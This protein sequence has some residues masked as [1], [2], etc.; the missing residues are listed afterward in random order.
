MHIPWICC[1]CSNNDKDE[2]DGGAPPKI[3]ISASFCRTRTQEGGWP[4]G[5][6]GMGGGGRQNPEWVNRRMLAPHHHPP[7]HTQHESY[8]TTKCFPSSNTITTTT[9]THTPIANPSSSSSSSS[10]SSIWIYYTYPHPLHNC[11]SLTHTQPPK[12]RIC[13]RAATSIHESSHSRSP[14]YHP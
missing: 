3:F 10:T 13:R 9:T 12:R 6:Y 14:N 2:D 11:S 7:T 8:C 4:T 5:D 1:C